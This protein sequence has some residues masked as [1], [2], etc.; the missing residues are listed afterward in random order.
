[1]PEVQEGFEKVPV[2]KV[3]VTAVQPVAQFDLGFGF[4]GGNFQVGVGSVGR[5]P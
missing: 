2:K 5:V 4:A 3:P 1:M